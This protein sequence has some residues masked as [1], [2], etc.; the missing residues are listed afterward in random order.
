MGFDS[1]RRY[2]INKSNLKPTNYGSNR[3]YGIST[4]MNRQYDVE[5]IEAARAQA[6]QDPF[7]RFNIPQEESSDY[8]LKP[9]FRS[10]HGIPVEEKIPELKKQVPVGMSTELQRGRGISSL[11]KGS[12][13]KFL[14][15]ENI[16]NRIGPQHP[17]AHKGWMGD[18]ALKAD[19][20]MAN[21][22][23]DPTER[24][25][26]NEFSNFKSQV[27]Q[28]L[29]EYLT[30]TTGAQ[31]GFPEISFLKPDVPN[32]DDPPDI[33]FSKLISTLDIARQNDEAMLESLDQQ[34]YRTRKLKG[35]MNYGIEE[36]MNR[37]RDIGINMGGNQGGESGGGSNQGVNI[38][39]ERK[40]AAT[41]IEQGADP[42]K[43]AVIFKQ[44]TGVD[45]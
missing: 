29:G 28:Q 42:Q 19:S 11:L 17:S 5:D 25:N 34:D 31:R 43:V 7:Q 36:L 39:Q 32:T 38:A 13:D 9:Q 20:I 22:M 26:I 35:G 24:S 44:I 37:G 6:S 30:Y 15:S 41:K 12:A 8:M 10:V 18:L 3:T 40:T 33:F 14:G 4:L 21:F 2:T 27:G 16:R 23:N 1:K 45:Y